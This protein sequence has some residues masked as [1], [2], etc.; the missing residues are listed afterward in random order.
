MKNISIFIK[1][2]E[3]RYKIKI[4]TYYIDDSQVFIISKNSLKI[5]N[6]YILMI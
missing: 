2:D 5:I 4:I 1:E 3:K 6:Y